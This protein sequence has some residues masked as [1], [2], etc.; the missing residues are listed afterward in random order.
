[1]TFNWYPLSYEGAAV[2]CGAT[3][4]VA[5]NTLCVASAETTEP[6]PLVT[7]GILQLPGGR[8]GPPRE[9]AGRMCARVAISEG[10]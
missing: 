8:S 1:M 4:S 3:A 5:G 2:V 10:A 9:G 6:H 7:E